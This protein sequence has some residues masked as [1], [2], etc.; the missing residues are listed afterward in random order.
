MYIFYNTHNPVI[1]GDN[2]YVELSNGEIVNAQIGGYHF[3]TANGNT[4]INSPKV[5]IQ[6]TDVVDGKIKVV[7]ATLLQPIKISWDSVKLQ[8][9]AKSGL[10]FYHESGDEVQIGDIV[11]FEAALE[12]PIANMSLG[13]IDSFYDPVCGLDK[14]NWE[15]GFWVNIRDEENLIMSIDP[16]E[17]SPAW[18]NIY[19]IRRS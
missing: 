10:L 16:L 3:E 19:Y 5:I 14:F 11:A 6:A 12:K 4:P 7:E 17:N 18:E 15:P 13:R 2:V 1:V 8:S 9:R